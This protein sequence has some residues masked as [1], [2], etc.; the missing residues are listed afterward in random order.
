MV[1]AKRSDT[2]TEFYIPVELYLSPKASVSLRKVCSSHLSLPSFPSSPI[3]LPFCQTFHNRTYHSL[4]PPS[5]LPLS[6]GPTSRIQ[7]ARKR[8][9]DERL[10]GKRDPFLS[11]PPSA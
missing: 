5:L 1:A 2:A 7:P 4:K 3:R 9:L 6:A 10:K 11:R 8:S